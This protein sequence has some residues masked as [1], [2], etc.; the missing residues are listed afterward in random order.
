MIIEIDPLLK[1]I[2]FPAQ[3]VGSLCIFL[4]EVDIDIFLKD[5]NTKLMI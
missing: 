2:P 4:L 1:Y 3:V 5:I